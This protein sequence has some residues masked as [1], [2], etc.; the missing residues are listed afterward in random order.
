MK[1]K[2][3]MAGI[4]QFIQSRTQA[5]EDAVIKALQYQGEEFVNTARNK[6]PKSLTTR[7]PKG[8]RFNDRTGNL[9]ASIGY[10]ILKNGDIID[11]FFPGET[12]E[13]VSVGKKAAAEV[14]EKYPSGIVLIGVAGMSYAA[15]VETLG[16]D[17][18]TGS[19]PKSK[20]IKDLLGAIKIKR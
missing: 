4:N 13:G 2:F 14:G 19:A 8:G 10:I 20:D 3:T 5:Y 11:S 7:L 18:I 1:A 16:F 12:S 9:A 6:A 15:A 17:V